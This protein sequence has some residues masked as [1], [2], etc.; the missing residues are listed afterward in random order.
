[1]FEWTEERVANYIKFDKE[2]LDELFG[3]PD[4]P[5]GKAMGRAAIR[6][7]TQSKRLCPVDTGLLRASVTHE[8][9]KDGDDL[10][11]RIGT[12]VHYAPYV[13]LGTRRMAARSYLRAALDILGGRIT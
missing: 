8:L 12:N 2:A 6:V 11:A 1:M 13:E 9:G 4:G 10:V 3:S 7:Q 5:M